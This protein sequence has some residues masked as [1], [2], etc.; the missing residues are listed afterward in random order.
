LLVNLYCLLPVILVSKSI[1]KG[2]Q[3]NS[4]AFAVTD[5]TSDHKR[6][7]VMVDGLTDLPEVGVT[8]TQIAQMVGFAFAVADVLGDRKGLPVMVD[9]LV[10]LSQRGVTTTQIA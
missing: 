1:P 6:L 5:V 7:A 10:D 4:F 8:Q 2:T 9:G 3:M